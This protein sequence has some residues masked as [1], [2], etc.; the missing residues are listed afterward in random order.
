[1]VRDLLRVVSDLGDDA[2]R[3]ARCIVDAG[4]TRHDYE[5]CEYEFDDV[6]GRLC[7]LPVGHE[8]PCQP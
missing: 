3:V 6:T 7:R 1:M 5:R 4:F 2:E 8:G